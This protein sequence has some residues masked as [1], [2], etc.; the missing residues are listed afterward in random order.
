VTC[1]ASRVNGPRLPDVTPGDDRIRL[2]RVIRIVL[3][4]SREGLDVSQRELAEKLGWSRNQIANIE[5]G[6]RAI[7][8]TDF[9]IIAKA[10]NIDPLALLHRVLRW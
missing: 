2:E 10:L 1:P 7:R 8:L 3:S 6:R 5:T 9:L 4:A